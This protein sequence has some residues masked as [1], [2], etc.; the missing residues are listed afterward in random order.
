MPAF[1]NLETQIKN[2]DCMFDIEVN[3]LFYFLACKNRW[4]VNYK[5]IDDNDNYNFPLLKTKVFVVFVISLSVATG[6]L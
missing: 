2:L 4:Y 1:M 6:D 3:K 5:L